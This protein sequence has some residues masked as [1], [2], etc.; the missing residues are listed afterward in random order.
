MF[1]AAWTSAR[2]T[3]G[4]AAHLR[5]SSPKRYGLCRS[6]P[7]RPSSLGYCRWASTSANPYPFPTNA[8]PTPHQIFHLPKDATRADVKARY[9]DLVRIYHPDSPSAR[10][11]GI[12]AETAHARFQAIAAAYAILTGKK[13][14]SALDG[15]GTGEGFDGAPRPTYHDLS[16][17]MWRARQRRRAELS[18]GLDDRWK[19]RLMLGAVVVVRFRCATT[20]LQC[21]R[22]W[23]TIRCCCRHWRYSSCRRTRHERK[24]CRKLGIV[25]EHL[26]AGPL[27]P[28]LRQIWTRR[29]GYH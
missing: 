28:R 4:P 15:S 10:A 14:A 12:P 22:H 13:P 6:R 7:S 17:A 25:E 9:Y 27:R 3:C 16:S 11:G 5:A 24:H 1:K 26:P 8:H 21:S 20:A 19:E 2:P 18:V 23:L 29:D